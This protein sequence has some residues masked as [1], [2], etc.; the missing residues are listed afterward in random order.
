MRKTCVFMFLFLIL[1]SCLYSPAVNTVFASVHIG[2]SS[3]DTFYYNV[4][5]FGEF[6]KDAVFSTKY[7]KVTVT[8]INGSWLQTQTVLHFNNDTEI[9]L[10]MERDLSSASS[11]FIEGKEYLDQIGFLTVWVFVAA[12]LN[13]ND[14]IFP[15]LSVALCIN[16]TAAKS[17]SGVERETTFLIRNSTTV[18][19]YYYVYDSA[20]FDKTTGALVEYYYEEAT[21]EGRSG[22]SISLTQSNVWA[23]PEFPSLIVVS[24]LMASIL[25]GAVVYRKK[26]HNR[27]N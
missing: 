20:Y 3:G 22:Y 23:I 16:G 7:L 17:Y 26:L 6:P 25:A 12:N 5:G 18:P 11:K 8:G 15:S 14:R 27:V 19:G 13:P 4:N 10:K 21:S 1:L 9:T 2:V 24:I